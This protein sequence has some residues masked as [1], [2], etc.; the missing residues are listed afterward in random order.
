MSYQNAMEAAGAEVL[1]YKEFGSYQGDWW[2]KVKFN[3]QVVWIH[4]SYGSCSGCDAF[5]GEFGWDEGK[6]NAHR[7]SYDFDPNTCVDCVHEIGRYNIRLTE[8]GMSYLTAGNFTQEEAE[9]MFKF[10]T[11]HSING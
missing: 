4:G 8:F 5:Q 2:A 10:I 7:Y 11:T 1:A 9:D 3:D 6:C